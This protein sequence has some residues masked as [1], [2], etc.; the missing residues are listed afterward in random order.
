MCPVQAIT[1]W[2]VLGASH[3][4]HFSAHLKKIGL[5]KFRRHALLGHNDMYLACF[6]MAS[7][8]MHNV[9]LGCVTRRNFFISLESDVSCKKKIENVGVSYIIWAVLI[10]HEI[11][12]K[13]ICALDHYA[14]E[15]TTCAFLYII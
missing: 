9:F 7:I 11:L 12:G 5:P 3:C 1:L 8:D 2:N 4:A 15:G 13:C 10:V 6:I 14:K